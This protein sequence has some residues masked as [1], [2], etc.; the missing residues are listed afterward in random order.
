MK[1]A[2]VTVRLAIDA[3]DVVVS[4]DWTPADVSAARESVAYD[5]A[6]EILRAQQR[7]Y[8]ARSSLVDYAVGPVAFVDAHLYQYE[9][10]EAFTPPTN[11]PQ[12]F[13]IV[14][15][16]HRHGTDA[17]PVFAYTVDLE[18]EAAAL[19]NFEPDRDEYLEEFGPFTAK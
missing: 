10:G 12:K 2:I 5:A 19:D 16:H 15:Y 18:A 4:S 9:E 13:W 17:W 11:A 14:V 3:S 7:K 6:N 8:D 1:L